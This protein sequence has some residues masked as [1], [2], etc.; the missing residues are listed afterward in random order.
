MGTKWRH[1]G[2]QGHIFTTLESCFLFIKQDEKS[3]EKLLYIFYFFSFTQIGSAM[4]L[5]RSLLLMNNP[6]DDWLLPTEE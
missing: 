6:N 3:R 1:Q 5:Q 2:H 4:L